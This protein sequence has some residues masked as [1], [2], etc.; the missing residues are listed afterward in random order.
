MMR[1]EVKR[2]CEEEQNA[3]LLC[4]REVRAALAWYK[5]FRETEWGGNRGKVKK[6]PKTCLKPFP[7]SDV[8]AAGRSLTPEQQVAASCL[9][10]SFASLSS[11]GVV[12]FPWW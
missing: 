3:E 8:F 1:M 4:L 11:E 12:Y 9:Q 2:P 5:E 6:L 10:N 7:L